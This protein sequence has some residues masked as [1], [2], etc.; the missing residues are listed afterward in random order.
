MRSRDERYSAICHHVDV[1]ARYIGLFCI[2]IELDI[3]ISDMDG[4]AFDIQ[5]LLLRS[6]LYVPKCGRCDMRTVKIYP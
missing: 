6:N 2:G 1:I 5:L 3:G 4:V